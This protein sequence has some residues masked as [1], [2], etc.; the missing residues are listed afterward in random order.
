MFE[1]LFEILFKFKP[2]Q[3]VEGKIGFQSGLSFIFFFALL[4]VL[5]VGIYIIYRRTNVYMSRRTSVVSLVLRLLA[6]IL[7]FFPLW[8]PVLLVPD[9]IPKENFLVI[10]ADKSASMQIEDGHFG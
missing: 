4:I 6:L 3:Y 10:L 5:G 9:I 7:L 8:Q 1:K 2:I